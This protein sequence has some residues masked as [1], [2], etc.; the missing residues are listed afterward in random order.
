MSK[1][2]PEMNYHPIKGEVNYCYRD[3]LW[4]YASLALTMERKR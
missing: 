2:N 4:Q 1:G 3:K